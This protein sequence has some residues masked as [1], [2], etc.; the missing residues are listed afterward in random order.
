MLSPEVDLFTYPD[1][2]LFSEPNKRRRKQTLKAREAATEYDIDF[3]ITV[4]DDDSEH[5]RS[6][7]RK[8]MVDDPL[9]GGKVFKKEKKTPKVKVVREFDSGSEGEFELPSWH[10]N[11]KELF[12]GMTL[13]SLF[14]I[15]ITPNLSSKPWCIR[16]SLLAHKNLLK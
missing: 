8:E 4:N 2:D 11:P 15:I 10:G 13:P 12:E 3:E 1:L 7:S 5:N 6:F 16:G 9:T 14:S